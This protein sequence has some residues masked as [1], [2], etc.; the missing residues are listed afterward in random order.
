MGTIESAN[1]KFAF[2]V[3]TLDPKGGLSPIPQ[4]GVFVELVA[5]GVKVKPTDT[6]APIE[7]QGKTRIQ[8][9]D[10]EI[11]LA[12]DG[13]IVPTDKGNISVANAAVVLSPGEQP[14]RPDDRGLRRRLE[15][16]SGADLDRQP[17]AALRLAQ[18]TR[19]CRSI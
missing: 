1:M 6:I 14:G 5:G 8:M 15:R 16:H 13:G 11:T 2:P 18:G 12:A 3:G 4:N 17:D 7:I 10:S 9:H 19:T